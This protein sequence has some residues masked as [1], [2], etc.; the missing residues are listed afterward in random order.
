[1][2]CVCVCVHV[3]LTRPPFSR[4]AL[5]FARLNG[6]LDTDFLVNVLRLDMQ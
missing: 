5:H 3:A 2:V 6:Y 1:M 4:F